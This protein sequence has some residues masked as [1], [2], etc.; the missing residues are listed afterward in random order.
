MPNFE[1]AQM[2]ALNPV[3]CP[4]GFARRAFAH[5]ES[6]ASLQIDPSKF[7]TLEEKMGAEIVK[8]ALSYPVEQIAENAGMDGKLIKAKLIE[9][10][11][12]NKHIGYDATTPITA[13]VPAM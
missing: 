1:M 12:K 5:P 2:A 6:V 4:C 7:D 10:W 9:A 13:T 8:N 3:A 11:K